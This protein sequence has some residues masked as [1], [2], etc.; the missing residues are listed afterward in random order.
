M[1]IIFKHHLGHGICLVGIRNPQI[2]IWYAKMPKMIIFPYA[3]N[4][5]MGRNSFYALIKI[6][7]N[8]IQI[9][10]QATHDP[11][12]KIDPRISTL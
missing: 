1:Y 10:F 6:S 4:W 5:N 3:L 2:L 8:Y 7:A 9:Y 12:S 11:K